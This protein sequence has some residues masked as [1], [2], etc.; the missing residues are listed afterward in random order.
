M[1]TLW[2]LS[3]GSLWGLRGEFSGADAIPALQI[4]LRVPTFTPQTVLDFGSGIGI[5]CW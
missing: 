4:Q 1:G 3:M 5:A 2:G